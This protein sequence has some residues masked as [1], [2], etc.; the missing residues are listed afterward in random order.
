ML[1]RWSARNSSEGTALVA[2]ITTRLADLTA[3]ERSL[4]WFVWPGGT[5]RNVEGPQR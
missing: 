3:P 1:H 5:V 4:F 2:R